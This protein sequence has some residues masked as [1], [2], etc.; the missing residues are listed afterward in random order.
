MTNESTNGTANSDVVLRGPR[1]QDLVF[2][3]YA[4]EVQ[5]IRG[6][7]FDLRRGET[8]AIVGE[9]GSGKSVTARSIMRLNPEANTMVRGGEILFDGQ[10]I[11][12]L[13]ERQMQSA[14]WAEDSDGVPRPH[15]LAGPDDEDRPPDHGEPQEA[16]RHVGQPRQ[17]AG[18]RATQDGRN[19]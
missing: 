7:S 11:L 12:K 16:P 4:G 5:A 6:A 19:S 8:L 13:S 15:D 3:T 10:G 18:H 14:A 17:R 2:S 1:S 9:S